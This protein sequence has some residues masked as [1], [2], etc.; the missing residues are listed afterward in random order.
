MHSDSASLHCCWGVFVPV[1]LQ[2]FEEVYANIATAY[3]ST[4]SKSSAVVF[5]QCHDHG[6]NHSHH[7]RT[8]ALQTPTALPQP[9][10]K[11]FLVR[12]LVAS[13]K[14]QPHTISSTNRSSIVISRPL[15][16][17]QT[18]NHLTLATSLRLATTTRTATPKSN[19][20]A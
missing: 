14:L 15:I 11:A 13:S 3:P 19:L 7:T 9:T 1:A 16:S 2:K 4:N 8:L 10:A 12:A 20:S 17:V 18:Q 5:S 6:L